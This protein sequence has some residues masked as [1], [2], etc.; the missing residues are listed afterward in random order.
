M[1]PLLS[2]FPN[3]HQ[4]LANTLILGEDQL[5]ND[6]LADKIFH[7]NEYQDFDHITIDCQSQGLDDLII[8]LS[9]ASIFSL[10]KIIYVKNPFFLQAKVA[11]KYQAQ[12]G[13]LEKIFSN[14][15]VSSDI[16]LVQA[17]YAKIDKRKKVAKLL[18]NNCNVVE[19]DLKP[20]QVEKVAAQLVK[21]EQIEMDQATFSLLMDRSDR[22][23]DTFL[24]NYNKL[25]A[26]SDTQHKITKELVEQNVDL[27]LT[28][29]VFL[30]LEQAL[31]G[32]TALAIE[33][34]KD[35]IR[36]GSNEIQIL[37]VF[38][39]QLELL[40]CVKV[41]QARR[42]TSQEIANTLEVHPYRVKLALQNK[43]PLTKLLN[44]LSRAI[45]LDFELKSGKVMIEQSLELLLLRI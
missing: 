20:Y 24:N 40:S 41:L 16:L 33:R 13:K 5:V 3:S 17:D 32:Q 6:Y 31:S 25:K 11:A 12:I 30:I 28:Q 18:L 19:T 9:E 27:T 38:I 21:L 39:S 7:A 23:F 22:Q 29:N 8:N 37:A 42:R 10:Q 15:T 45:E 4:Q 34:L 14:L 36:Y 44:L 26:I 1:T 35:Q 43:V 2:L